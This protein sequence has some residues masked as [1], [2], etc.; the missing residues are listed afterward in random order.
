MLKIMNRRPRQHFRNYRQQKNMRIFNGILFL[1]TFYTAS[2]QLKIPEVSPPGSLIQKIGFTTIEVYYERPAARGRSEEEIFGKLVPFGKVWRTGAGNCTTISFDTDVVMNHQTIRKGKYALFTIPD[3]ENWIVILNTDTLAYG[4]YNYDTAKDII[5]MEVKALR[6]NRYYE[7]LTIDIDFIPNNARIY[8]SWLNTQISFDINTGLDDQILSF[9]REHLI[10]HDSNNPELYELAI[11]YYFWHQQDRTQLM[12]FIDRGIELNNDRM[13][14]YWKVE[15][16]MKDK[17]Y[18]EARTAAA[19]AINVIRN[20]GETAERKIELI[21][22][23]ELYIM[24]I[25]KLN[26]N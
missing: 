19:S 26:K 16:L 20:S 2:A 3:K 12:K 9:I 6:S 7:A 1:I 8:I 14:Y 24:Q 17:R 11:T 18:V 5:R 15:E 23:F 22:D 21:K 25:D 4:A 13:W 10:L